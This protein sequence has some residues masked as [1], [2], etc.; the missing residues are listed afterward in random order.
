M[1]ASCKIAITIGDMNGIGPEVTL[2]ALKEW[3]PPAS[4]Q[5]VLIGPQWAYAFWLDKLGVA[6]S[7]PAADGFSTL[8]NKPIVIL[9]VFQKTG[10]IQPGKI[11]AEAGKIAGRAIDL[12]IELCK[13]QKC[14]AMVTAPA[15]KKGLDLG[16]Y[17]FPGQTELIADKLGIGNFAMMLL[18]EDFRVSPVTTHLPLKRVAQA[19]SMERIVDKLKTLDRELRTRFGLAE[20]RLAVTALNPHAGE[21][22]LL[23]DEEQRLIAP[24]LAQAKEMG[25]QVEGPF[26]ADALFGRLDRNRFDCYMAMYHDQ[27]LIPLKMRG[28]GR[29]VNYT[30]GLPI[31]RTSPDH[32][33]A[34]DIAGTNSAEP[35]SMVEALRLAVT[36]A[37]KS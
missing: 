36:L 35:T 5:I 15:S 8:A 16:G 33:T 18:V 1:P 2:K 21:G 31:I 29:A 30:A 9:D 14:Q 7:Y 13:E 12:A 37:A 10:T 23:G 34:Y 25:I 28:F 22:G 20:P 4:C 11:T 17:H 27:A 19:I 26:P 24:A 3:K 6:A 32:G